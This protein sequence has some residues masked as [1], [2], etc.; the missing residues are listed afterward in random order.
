MCGIAGIASINGRPVVPNA[1]KSMCDVL[2]HRGPDDGG[3]VFFCANRP[4]EESG[5][6]CEFAVN[7]FRHRNQH[8]PVYGGEYSRHQFQENS[9]TLALGHRRLSII[10]LSN[11]A[12]QPMSSSNG[13]YWIVY[14]GMIYNYLELRSILSGQGH[15]FKSR[16]DTEVVLQMWERYGPDCLERLNGMFAFAVYDRTENSITLVRDRYGIKPLYYSRDRDY[17]IF[18]SE[19]K[20]IIAS[21]A[22]Q[23]GVDPGALSDYFSFQNG[24]GKQ[25]LFKGIY[26][27]KPGECITC[28]PCNGSSI[29]RNRYH[30]QFPVVD[31]DLLKN[32]S[33]LK[34]EI[35]DS[36][37][38]AVKRQLLSDVDV[39]AY[40]S[41]GMDSGS[42]IA[43]ATKTLPGLMTFTGGFDLT[44]VSGIEQGY[45][46][47]EAAEELSCLFQTDH[48][49]VVLQSGDMPAA[50]EALTWHLDDPRVGMCHQNWYV[51]KL[52]SRFVKVCLS[53]VGGD[54]LFG[55]YPWRYRHAI[56]AKD[57]RECDKLNFSYW[58]RSIPCKEMSKLFV[59]ELQQYQDRAFQR[60][61]DVMT[62]APGWQD[63]LS[64][65]DN[66]LQRL[67]YFEFKTFLHGILRVE[68]AVSMAHGLETR[69]PFLD[70]DLVDLAWKLPPSLKIN[71]LQLQKH[72]TSYIESADGKRILRQAMKNY[73]PEEFIK[74]P[75]QGFS[76][77]DENWFRGP[78]MD[79]IK[80][81]L[82][83][84][85]TTERSWFDQTFLQ[86]KLDEHFK[87]I[88]NHRLFIWSL[89]NFEWLQ[90]HF[91]DQQDNR[92]FHGF[93]GS[94]TTA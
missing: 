82:F 84:K 23:A 43:V 62:D 60:F 22:I 70:N 73:L 85:Q 78:S 86:A 90:R 18:A 19:I 8:L 15:V 81:V 79:Y 66:M 6:W 65:Q 93:I 1:I 89:L 52:A 35:V 31:L 5:S 42:I 13:R 71:T 41:G 58:H 53:G 11:E 69:V 47:R 57:F 67:L 64:P 25:T 72:A 54:E 9:F 55:G 14:N 33:R 3:Y 12:H 27:V 75:K 26:N 94:E 37:A 76:P 45:D 36:F 24:L 63:E 51:S 4:L 49:S 92:K 28:R 20:G 2:A 68:D 30:K 77:P 39:G 34:N 50:M 59:P 46:E 29:V 48:H 61:S 91:I 38:T 83:D 32:R 74:Q 88:H 16:S 7:Q 87:G 10:D 80:S 21:G 44:N 56:N 40:L 17:F